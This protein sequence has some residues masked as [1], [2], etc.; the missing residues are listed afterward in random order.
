MSFIISCYVDYSPD[1]RKGRSCHKVLLFQCKISSA[2]TSFNDALDLASDHRE[3]QHVC[4]YEI[5]ILPALRVHIPF[6]DVSLLHN[7]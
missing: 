7:I 2:L 4:L 3:I 1:W 5:G 6:A